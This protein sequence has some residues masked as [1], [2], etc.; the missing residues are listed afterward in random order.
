M[1]ERDHI[2]LARRLAVERAL[3]CRATAVREMA[4]AAAWDLAAS[5]AL[6]GDEGVI[7]ALLDAPFWP[8]DLTAT[9]LCARLGLNRGEEPRE[10][11]PV[12]PLAGGLPASAPASP[13]PS[14]RDHVGSPGP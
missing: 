9:E 4:R 12:R 2:A 5:S 8:L 13:D 3:A 14:P 7:A 11:M 1:S 10:G 6:R